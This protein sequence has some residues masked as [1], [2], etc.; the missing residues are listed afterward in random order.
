MLSA[1]KRCTKPPAPP[2]LVK[3]AALNKIIRF[4]KT[5]KA[6]MT[7]GRNDDAELAKITEI[8]PKPM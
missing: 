1:E 8:I 4:W 2:Y 6:N 7:T 5:V 3:L